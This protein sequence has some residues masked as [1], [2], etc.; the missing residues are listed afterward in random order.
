MWK[1]KPGALFC[2]GNEHSTK[3]GWAGG[4]HEVRVR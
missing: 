3:A 4:L 2:E 1:T